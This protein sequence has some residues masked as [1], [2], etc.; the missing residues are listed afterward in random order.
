MNQL[1]QLS[2]NDNRTPSS[3]QRQQS[4]LTSATPKTPNSAQRRG[5]LSVK[6][7][8]ASTARPLLYSKIHNEAVLRIANLL[9]ESEKAKNES[10][11]GKL[12]VEAAYIVMKRVTE[13]SGH[14]ILSTGISTFNKL[15]SLSVTPALSLLKETNWKEYFMKT[16]Q[17]N[18]PQS[19]S[20]PHSAVSR[21]QTPPVGASSKDHNNNISH[22]KSAFPLNQDVTDTAKGATAPLTAQEQEFLEVRQKSFQLLN[23]LGEI[24]IERIR[25]LWH[26]LKIPR[27]EQIFYEKSICSLPIQ[28]M[29]QC[30]E[31]SKLIYVLQQHE[32]QTRAVLTKIQQ[33]EEVIE[34]CMDVIVM[35]QRK[36]LH[37]SSVVA[38][39]PQTGQM[40]WKEEL[41]QSLY[42]V[43]VTSMEVIK[44]IQE[45]RRSLWRPLPFIWRGVDYLLKMKTD[46]LPIFPA[47]SK[48]PTSST[49]SLGQKAGMMKVVEMLPLTYD[50]LQGVVFISPDHQYRY[51]SPKRRTASSTANL[52]SP[53]KDRQYQ[54]YI[55]SLLQQYDVAYDF[56]DLQSAAVI[57][58]EEEALQ[59]AIHLEQQALV[60]KGVF[61][62]ILR[63]MNDV[64]VESADPTVRSGFANSQDDVRLR[65]SPSYNTQPLTS[66]D[67]GN[68]HHHHQNANNSHQSSRSRAEDHRNHPHPR[69]G[70]GRS[71]DIEAETIVITSNSD[72]SSLRR[73]VSAQ[74]RNQVQHNADREVSMPEEESLDSP[75]KYRDDFA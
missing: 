5:S 63:P 49:T 48:P 55:D 6:L 28:S 51:G 16:D 70:G 60:N 43:R 53:S 40:F 13:A 3:L 12:P 37:T 42:E 54:A 26:T 7:R 22:S 56:A 21:T 64:S 14:P 19:A 27:K 45:W 69:G 66:S 23:E 31:L 8:K 61:I 58:L 25:S 2:I 52:Q 32:Q 73:P 10:T 20:R 17:K 39:L 59:K 18:H 38:P 1:P 65:Q 11:K 44:A 72:F 62:P 74:S 9:Q 34:K 4:T 68:Q 57:V 67:L 47:P 75:S 46:F 33:R 71:D 41:I 24:M 30:K 50:D 29:E 36:F 35:L 15:N